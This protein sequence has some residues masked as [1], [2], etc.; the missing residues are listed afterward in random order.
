[1][2][3]YKYFYWNKLD[4]LIRQNIKTK[5]YLKYKPLNRWETMLDFYLES[6][7]DFVSLT[8]KEAL[9]YKH[10]QDEQTLARR[11]IIACK[12]TIKGTL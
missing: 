2:A 12:N 11:D 6:V 5:K 1:M 7:N 9:E 4:M 3:E 10:Q 8:E